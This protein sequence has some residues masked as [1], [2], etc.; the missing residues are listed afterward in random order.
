M[1]ISQ[2]SL[3][4]LFAFGAASANNDYI[5]PSATGLGWEKAFAQA[6]SLVAQM[7]FLLAVLVY[8]ARL[9]ARILHAV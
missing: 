3:L 7:T 5:S 4:L 6:K 1:K 2:P 8:I 9:T